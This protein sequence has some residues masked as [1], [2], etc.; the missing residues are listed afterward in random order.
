VSHRIIFTPRARA[1]AVEAF[2]WIAD[3]SP[4]AAVRWYAG[5]EKVIATL[6]QDPERHPIAEDES[7]QFG[8]TMRQL[9]Y[10]RRR[11]VY[12]IL[13]SVEGETVYLHSVRHTARGPIET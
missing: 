7:E 4:T 6:E 5:L 9:L 12:R 10:G 11:G 13:F 2:R 3:Q 1:D 8:F